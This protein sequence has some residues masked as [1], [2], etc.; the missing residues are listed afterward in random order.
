MS[1]FQSTWF[2]D[3]LR[4]TAGMFVASN[5]GAILG[6][7]MMP[8]IATGMDKIPLTLIV[9]AVISSVAFVPLIFMP[10][11]PK[12]PPSY[13]QATDR[14]PFIEGLKMLSKN[15]HFWILFT[16]H[17]INVG[18]S[19]ALATIFNQVITPYGYTNAQSGQLSAVSFFAG[20]LGCFQKDSFAAIMFTC[21]MNQFFLSFLV[22]VVVELGVEVSYPV[23]ESTSNSLL[24][25]GCQ[26][27]G[28]VFVLI[29]DQLRDKDGEPK[30]NMQKALILQA[31]LMGVCTILA[32]VYNGRMRRSEAMAEE[33]KEREQEEMDL[34]ELEP[35]RWNRERAGSIGSE[36]SDATRVEDR[37]CEKQKGKAI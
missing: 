4:A 24:W 9:V 7:F 33:Q 23:A 37:D 2:T 14:P 13:A 28:F 22:P 21:I 1:M 32:F 10:A 30:D 6:M 25:Q 15:G 27:F 8:A 36:Q 34:S 3:N 11:K 5:Y 29:M 26:L 16:V 17:G 31:A 12:T 19:I 35:P 18:L 20:T